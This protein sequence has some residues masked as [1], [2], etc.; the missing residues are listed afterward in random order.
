M[1]ALLKVAASDGCAPGYQ[2]TVSVTEPARVSGWPAELAVRSTRA[3][4]GVLPVALAAATAVRVAEAVPPAGTV[5]VS[6]AGLSA[7]SGLV[8][9]SRTWCQAIVTGRAAWLV[10]SSLVACESP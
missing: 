4:P 7:K 9:G 3:G 10:T 6:S 5:S 1:A 2:R 8:L